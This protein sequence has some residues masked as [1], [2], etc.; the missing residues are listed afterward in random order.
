MADGEYAMNTVHSDRSIDLNEH[1]ITF[2]FPAEVSEDVQEDLEDNSKF[3]EDAIMEENEVDENLS[4]E[5]MQENEII[6]DTFL[7]P[8]ELIF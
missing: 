3:F 4:P 8:S 6:R 1:Y 2:N 7:Y 5:F